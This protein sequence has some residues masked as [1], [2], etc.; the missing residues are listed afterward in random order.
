MLLYLLTLARVQTEAQG[1]FCSQP[2]RSIPPA[3]CTIVPGIW[4]RLQYPVRGPSLGFLES[5][6][7]LT[8]QRDFLREQAGGE[9]RM[10]AGG[11]AFVFHGLHLSFLDIKGC[12][13]L[14]SP[15]CHLYVHR[16][17]ALAAPAPPL[18]SPEVSLPGWGGLVPPLASFLVLS[19][20]SFQQAV[21][22]LRVPM[23]VTH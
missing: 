10:L 16:E 11:S 15:E 22:A 19:L 18:S 12:T 2:W 3:S 20:H 4:T 17:Q 23:R 7:M 5:A 9:G 14:S 21:P 8:G 6:P 13:C 1:G